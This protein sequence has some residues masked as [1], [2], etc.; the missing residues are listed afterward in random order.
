MKPLYKIVLET[1]E[2]YNVYA[3]DASKA[4]KHALDIWPD[5]FNKD[6]IEIYQIKDP[7]S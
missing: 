1:G 6:V 7:S 2:E 4:Y 5:I 3:D